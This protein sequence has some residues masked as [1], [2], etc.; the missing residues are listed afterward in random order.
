MKREVQAADIGIWVSRRVHSRERLLGLHSYRVRTRFCR[1]W[2]VAP[3]LRMEDVQHADGSSGS[4][5]PDRRQIESKAEEH[6]RDCR[7]Q[8]PQDRMNHDPVRTNLGLLRQPGQDLF[9]RPLFGKH[10]TQDGIAAVHDIGRRVVV[11]NNRRGG[12]AEQAP[13]GQC[14]GKAAI[15]LEVLVLGLPPHLEGSVEVIR[16]DT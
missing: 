9:V 7:A 11:L 13:G 1:K 8:A 5:D 3:S 15:E 4:D 16:M 14:V 6:Q 10:P 2:A 12:C